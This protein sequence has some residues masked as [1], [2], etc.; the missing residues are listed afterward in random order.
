MVMWR[1]FL[2]VSWICRGVLMRNV[3]PWREGGGRKGTTIGGARE[4][5]QEMIGIEA[6]VTI[7]A[8]EMTGIG[9]DMMTTEEAI[10]AIG[11]INTTQV[12]KMP[13]AA[14]AIPMTG[15]GLHTTDVRGM[16]ATTRGRESIV[17]NA[18][19]AA[20]AATTSTTRG[21]KSRSSWKK[22]CGANGIKPPPR[23]ERMPPGRPLLK[24]PCL[25]LGCR[26]GIRRK[27]R[28]GGHVGTMASRRWNERMF[29]RASLWQ[30]RLLRRPWRNWL[31]LKRRSAGLGQDMVDNARQEYRFY[32][33]TTL[34]LIIQMYF[35]NSSITLINLTLAFDIH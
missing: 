19:E 13:V 12:E 17:A 14:G 7:T 32:A 29:K 5:I 35:S 24:I 9:M 16:I 8:G 34:C 11:T 22:S 15:V 2:W 25:P 10:V 3:Q 4:I 23:A 18:A 31:P 1:S 26:A 30:H 20:T 21:A 28:I 6:G 33:Y 27:G